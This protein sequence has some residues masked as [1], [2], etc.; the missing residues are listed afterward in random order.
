MGR[1]HVNLSLQFFKLFQPEAVVIELV[2]N[3]F[4]EKTLILGEL[5]SCNCLCAYLWKYELRHFFV[6]ASFKIG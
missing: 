4:L 3:A 2:F 6:T 5:M 1:V